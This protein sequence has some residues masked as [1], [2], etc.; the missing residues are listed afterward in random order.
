KLIDGGK[1]DNLRGFS[2]R[3]LAWHRLEDL[4]T[5][6]SLRGGV[7]EGD[8]MLHLHWQTNF[9]LLSGATNSRL[10]YHEAA[11]LARAIDDGWGYNCKELMTL[12]SKAKQFEAG[13]KVS[14]GGKEYPA[15]Y[16]PRNDTLINLFEIT[17]D[18]QRELRTIISKGMAAE[19]HRD[20]DTERRRAAGAVDRETYLKAAS[21]KQA[22]AQEL[23][24]QGLSVRA[25]AEQMDISKTAVG[26][27]IQPGKV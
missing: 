16:T 27:Y 19:R 1:S 12:Y 11:T 26:R 25:I 21:N 3:Q 24:A 13:E 22:Q 23:R 20:R 7:A 15:L 10:M 6:M 4:R 9:L 2:G 18:E 8:R 17:D 14:F 5:L